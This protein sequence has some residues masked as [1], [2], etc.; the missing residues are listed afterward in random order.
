MKKFLKLIFIIL[1]LCLSNTLLAQTTRF[2][3]GFEGFAEHS[4]PDS[5]V[6]GDNRI[7]GYTDVSS[8]TL[9]LEPGYELIA[10]AEIIH[11]LDLILGINSTSG[12]LTSSPYYYELNFHQ[13]NFPVL[14][15]YNYSVRE[16]H[17]DFFLAG[18]SFGKILQRELSS[19]KSTW[20]HSYLEDWNDVSPFSLQ[21]GW[22]R[23]YMISGKSGIII[24]PYVNFELS[25]NEILKTFFEPFSL[26]VKI[27][28]EFKI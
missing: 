25:K 14:V 26:G 17:A 5:R 4:F 18:I 1:Y 19:D 15:R 11:R 10:G 12:H 21:M 2:F 7:L 22:G 23:K 9:F 28:Y 24:N 3:V 20:Q 13:I 6:A 16:T 27:A 8:K